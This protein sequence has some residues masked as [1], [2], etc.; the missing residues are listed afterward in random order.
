MTQLEKEALRVCVLGVLAMHQE[1]MSTL[2]VARELRD[3]YTTQQ[4]SMMMRQLREEGKINTRYERF[5]NST[6][7]PITVE[8]ITEDE[9]FESLSIFQ[10]IRLIILDRLEELWYD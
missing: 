6:L 2:E 1:P 4:V 7:P 9:Y 3:S 5:I 10:K 8:W